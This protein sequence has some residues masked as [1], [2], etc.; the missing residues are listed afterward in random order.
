MPQSLSKMISHLV[1]STKHREPLIPA[2]KLPELHAF[3]ATVC[4]EKGCEAYRVGGV[5]NHVHIALRWGRTITQ[6]DLVETIK[7]RTSH[8]M[9]LT[10]PNFHWQDGYGIFSVSHSHLDRLTRYIDNQWE[11]HH[12]ESYP[13]ELRNLCIHYDVELDERY[14]WD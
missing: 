5:E 14:A 7:V 1:F 12:H 10:V 3:L 13:D 4:R 2:E 11:H 9:K 8:W 6:A